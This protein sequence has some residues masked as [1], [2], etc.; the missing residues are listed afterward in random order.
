ML[1][2][3]HWRTDWQR[4]LHEFSHK[5]M[6][7]EAE[8]KK[9]RVYVD[10]KAS[11]NIAPLPMI[12][13]SWLYGIQ[14]DVVRDTATPT[15]SPWWDASP[16]WFN[17][18]TLSPPLWIRPNLLQLNNNIMCRTTNLGFCFFFSTLSLPEATGTMLKS[19]HPSQDTRPACC[20]GWCVDGIMLKDTNEMVSNHTWNGTKG[21]LFNY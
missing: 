14:L 1:Q 21:K 5:K 16:A 3:I 9:T 17:P 18:S 13:E 4:N 6:N 12:L 11:R 20:S 7:E 2:L 10:S 15:P 19:L 8:L